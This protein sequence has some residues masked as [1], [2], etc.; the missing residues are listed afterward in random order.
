MLIPQFTFAQKNFTKEFSW[1]FN[2]GVSISSVNFTSSKYPVRQ[3]K[4]LQGVGGLTVRYIS[5]KNFGLQCELNYSQR[6][7]KEKD[8]DNPDMHYTRALDY[9]ELP[10]LTHVYFNAGKRFRVIFN[11]G[12]QLGYLLN[13]RVVESTI[14]T[15]N[16][17][18]PS[19]Y[20]QNVQRRFDW[21]LCFGGGV[22]LRTGVGNFVLDGRYYY[23]LSD[24]FNNSR[25]DD[26]AS[27]SNQVIGVKLT[28]FLKSN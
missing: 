13:E 17:D 26:F 7:W 15:S 5:E 21:G 12:P 6:G 11:L 22:E 24:I 14:D 19:Y 3:G 10:V 1:G 9:I 20:S 25:A 2:G 28:Y 4:L 27:S 23:G 18:T 16:P 8:P